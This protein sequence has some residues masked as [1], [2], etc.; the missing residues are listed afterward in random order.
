MEG[1]GKESPDMSLTKF[2]DKCTRDVQIGHSV[3]IFGQANV[4]A[5]ADLSWKKLSLDRV[6]EK[7][8]GSAHPVVTLSSSTVK[9]H[10]PKE[11]LN[12]DLSRKMCLK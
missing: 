10:V 1:K 12:L 4:M 3:S 11:V 8:L 5:C 7:K 9:C 2:N 6:C